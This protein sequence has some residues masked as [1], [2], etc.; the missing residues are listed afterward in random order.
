MVWLWF[1]GDPKVPQ[2][3][4]EGGLVVSEGG[5]VVVWSWL[6]GGS[7]LIGSGPVLT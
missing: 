2:G 4:S 6:S 1:D 3:W 7:R 5:S